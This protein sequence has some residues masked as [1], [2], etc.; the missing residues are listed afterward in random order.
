MIDVDQDDRID[1]ATLG[2]LAHLARMAEVHT[3]IPGRVERY[4]AATQRADV[5]PLVQRAVPRVDGGT[6]LESL[7]VVRSVP[8]LWPHAGGYFVHLPLAAGDDVLLVVSEVDPSRYLESGQPGAPIDRRRH[9][10]SHAF[11]IPGVH[12]N[13]GA[14]VAGD[15]LEGEL[16]IGREGEGPLVRVTESAIKIGRNATEKA[17]KAAPT[18]ARL[19]ALEG[20]I[21]ALVNAT[22]AA[23][24]GGAAI[25]SA[26]DLFWGAQSAPGTDIAAT[27]AEVE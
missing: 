4:D 18:A 9:H 12:P 26:V 22:P 24:D 16:V 27:V 21:N 25:Q 17:A 10:L 20:A 1:E 15:A 13:A 3:A 6:L 8:V 23:N 2:A 5:Q 19:T 11:A 14:L 7:P